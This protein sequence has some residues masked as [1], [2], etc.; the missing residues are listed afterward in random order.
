LEI[1]T[2]PPHG[3]PAFVAALESILAV[4]MSGVAEIFKTVINEMTHGTEFNLVNFLHTESANLA[5][6]D[7]NPSIDKPA[8]RWN[9]HLVSYDTLTS[10]AK[11][12]SNGQ[13]SYGEWS[14]GIF[15][16]Y[17]LYK[18]KNIVGRQM[19]MNAKIELKLQVIATPGFN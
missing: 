12:S 7:L 19:S 4:T 8:N 18:T 13:S 11:L 5:H 10:R 9:I 6:E 14:F 16:H 2:T 3:H 1:Q 17:H 15:D